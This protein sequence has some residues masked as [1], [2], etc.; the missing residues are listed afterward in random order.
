MPM[1]HRREPYDAFTQVVHVGNTSVV[2][3]TEGVAVAAAQQTIVP[4]DA[5]ATAGVPR[6][7]RLGAVQRPV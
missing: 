2:V 1:L 6:L 5:G 4:P 3:E 7:P